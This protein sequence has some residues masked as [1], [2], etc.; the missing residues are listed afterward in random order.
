MTITASTN[1]SIYSNNN[2]S[3]MV[4]GDEST[5]FWSSHDPDS[6]DY[7]K[8]DLGEVLNLLSVEI[9]MDSGNDYM[10]NGRLEYSTDNSSW[11]SIGT[12]SQ[13]TIN[14]SVDVEARYVRL[15]ATDNFSSYWL[16]VYEFSVESEPINESSQ[17]WE[18][19]NTSTGRDGSLQ[20]F[21]VPESAN[22]EIEAWG[23]QGGYSQ[24]GRG[25]GAKIRGTFFIE[26]GTRLI[27]LVGQEGQNRY[28]DYDSGGGGGTYV[29]KEDTESSYSLNG[30]SSEF[31]GTYVSPLIIAGGAGGDA[32][33]GSGD[34]G[35]TTE[36][37]TGYYVNTNHGHGASGRGYGGGGGGYYSNGD[38]G[39][40][41]GSGGHGFLN[42]GLG[43]YG[44]HSWGGFGGGAGG[45]SED[46]AGGGGWTGGNSHDNRSRAS[47]G[48]G[49]LNKGTDQWASTGNWGHGK[50]T[51]TK[52]FT[53]PQ[54]PSSITKP[55]SSLEIISGEEVLVSWEETPNSGD[56]SIEDVSYEVEFYNGE[57]WLT[58]DSL[59]K[60]SVLHL[61]PKDTRNRNNIQYRVRATGDN[62]SKSSWVT[63]STFKTRRSFYLVKDENGD[64]T[65]YK[66]LDLEGNWKSIYPSEENYIQYGITDLS[67]LTKEKLDE[68]GQR[69]I[70]LTSVSTV[71][72]I[73]VKV[74]GIPSSLVRYK[75][76]VVSPYSFGLSSWSMFTPISGSKVF[77]ITIP[78]KLFRTGEPHTVRV[79]AEDSEGDT[80]TDEIVLTLQ[81]NKP[82]LSISVD[83]GTINIEATD[84]DDDPVQIKALLND[85]KFYPS[86]SD[87]S[88]FGL[89]GINYTT[90]LNQE[91]VQVGFNN[92]VTV[93]AK[94]S[95]GA[96]TTK[97][98]NFIGDSYGLVF[99][100]K[101]ETMYSDA[102]GYVLKTLYHKDLIAGNSSDWVEVWVKNTAGYDLH[103]VSL[104]VDQGALDPETETVEL[105]KET[106][107]AEPKQVLD[108]GTVKSGNKE[109][110]FVRV[111]AN[112]DAIIG[113]KFYVHS[114][115]DPL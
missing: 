90:D 106:E 38:D 28:G 51:I 24:N 102:L 31:D 9:I 94:D 14:V 5:K 89:E 45:V 104:T 12:Y 48:G 97:V 77:D 59:S 101:E 76:D 113:G 57:S 53:P 103:N 111:D 71:P 64:E 37:S 107:P 65:S 52:I 27:M 68:L 2:P 84:E 60:T 67:V 44:N 41:N 46:G 43:G 40:D 56:T 8:I 66:Y 86:D 32:S 4:D 16:Q 100:D 75:V 62:D 33:D 50:V 42:G 82:N 13:S 22:Y 55:E 79:T 34:H 73:D 88:H 3:N 23:A 39:Y 91:D 63:S 72:D 47:G 15:R 98:L 21:V 110:F 35:S 58:V 10:R 7:V 1:M 30:Y 20:E 25:S 115:A 96:E 83:G 29:V 85:S 69:N 108:L 81:N 6:G 18:F 78:T 114:Q 11:S 80:D 17:S 61:V 112:E 105:T 109:S 19:N 36:D 93:T 92:K 26:A 87:F 74:T 95:Y 49:S 70:Y 54:P 99:M